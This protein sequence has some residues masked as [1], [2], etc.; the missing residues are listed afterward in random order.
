MNNLLR[1]ASYICLVLLF[2]QCTSKKPASGQTTFIPLN[3]VTLTDQFWSRYAATNR[4]ITI[5]HIF[6]KCEEMGLIQNFD[7]ASGKVQG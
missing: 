4:Q 3:Q 1:I 2:A 7:V 5:P 6:E